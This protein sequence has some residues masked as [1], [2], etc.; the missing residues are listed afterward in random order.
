MTVITSEQN[1][2]F[3]LPGIAFRTLVSP[4]RGGTE[5]A[6]WRVNLGPHTPGTP[7]RLT[8]QEV[9]HVVAGEVSASIAGKTMTARSGDTIVVPAMTDFALENATSSPAEIIAFMA[10]GGQAL[11]GGEPAFTPPWAE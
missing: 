3:N 11:V 8:R 2:T 4:V 10:A 5:F 6:M 7:H 1:Q 9:L